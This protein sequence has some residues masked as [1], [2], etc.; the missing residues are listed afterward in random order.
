[1]KR[2]AV[3]GHHA[4]RNAETDFIPLTGSFVLHVRERSSPGAEP[5]APRVGTGF[6]RFRLATRALH[7]PGRSWYHAT[8][9]PGLS[10]PT[11]RD[12]FLTAT[13]SSSLHISRSPPD[14]SRAVAHPCSATSPVPDLALH[15][16]IWCLR[17]HVGGHAR[18][19]FNLSPFDAWID[20]VR[21]LGHGRP[22][23]LSA[24]EALFAAR[25]SEPAPLVARP[26]AIGPGSRP[27][28]QSP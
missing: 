13:V 22:T 17:E 19:S 27:E 7:L 16:P 9:D 15:H 20:R 23:G 10:L 11:S 14:T 2:G 12:R 26:I 5:V 8:T 3:L 25:R 6:H 4:A 28:L 1:M 18:R 21:A 24:I